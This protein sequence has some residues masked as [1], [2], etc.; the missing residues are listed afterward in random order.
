MIS[1]YLS[2]LTDFSIALYVSLGKW[3]SAI[4]YYREFSIRPV[5]EIMIGITC[6][7]NR[8]VLVAFR[9]VSFL[10]GCDIR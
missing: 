3:K 9:Y 5:E 1:M 2:S 8:Y 4:T 6:V 10:Y 7:S